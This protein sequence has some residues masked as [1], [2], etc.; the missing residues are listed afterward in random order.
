MPLHCAVAID[1]YFN[2]LLVAFQY[3]PDVNFGRSLIASLNLEN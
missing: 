1:Y 2:L 3:F